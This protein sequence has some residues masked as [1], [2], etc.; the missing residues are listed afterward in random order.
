MAGV[1]R[2][3]KRKELL[4]QIFVMFLQG[5]PAMLL[6]LLENMLESDVAVVKV[7]YLKFAFGPFYNLH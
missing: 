1:G 4:S 2:I 3:K 7:L 5:L 6:P